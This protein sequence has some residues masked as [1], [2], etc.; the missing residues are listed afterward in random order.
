[1]IRRVLLG[2]TLAAAANAF[3]PGPAL[4]HHCAD[5]M[6]IFSYPLSVNSNVAAC[7]V[8][9][10][11]AGDT[12]IINPAS[13]QVSV[14]FTQ[15]FGAGTPEITAVVNG[16]GIENETIT[17]RMAMILAFFWIVFCSVHS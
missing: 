1:M 12:R 5:T 3:V 11:D 13:T 7:I 15:D 10:E 9:G 4:A 16:L 8:A 2:C 17:M 6:V 14:R